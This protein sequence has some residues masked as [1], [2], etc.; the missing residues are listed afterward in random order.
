M[1]PLEPFIEPCPWC[2]KPSKT[3]LEGSY[4]NGWTSFV[5][6][7]DML[8]CGARGP[9]IRTLGLSNDNW[10]TED[11]AIEAWNLVVGLINK[12]NIDGNDKS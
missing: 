11:R 10:D 8:D 9:T 6:C 1:R 4:V 7:S 12:E 2:K 5:Y 3:Y